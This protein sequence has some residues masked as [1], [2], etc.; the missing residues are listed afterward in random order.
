MLRTHVD[1]L[2]L[3]N[4]FKDLICVFYVCMFYLHACI[5]A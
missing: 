3:L 2:F 4:V 5:F 1:S